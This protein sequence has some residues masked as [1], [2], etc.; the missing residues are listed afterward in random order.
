[1]TAKSKF[2]GTAEKMREKL[3]Y[4]FFLAKWQQ[5]S[6]H[7]PIGLTNS[8]YHPPLH[9]IDAAPLTFNPSALH[10]WDDRQVQ[11]VDTLAELWEQYK[12]HNVEQRTVVGIELRQRMGLPIVDMDPEDSEIFKHH[13]KSNFQNKGPMVRE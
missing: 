9:E 12:D 3:G 11:W 13:Y 2:M 5:V 4:A 10:N 7:L 6:L 1:M 8:C